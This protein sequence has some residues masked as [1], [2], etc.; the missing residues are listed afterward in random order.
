MNPMPQ[1]EP[2]LKQLRL[3]GVVDSLEAR[4]RQAIEGRLA[5]TDFLALLLQDE[6]ARR[7]QRHFAQRLRRAQVMGDK[8]LDRF[9]PEIC[10]GLNSGLLADLSTC[11]F[12]E[13]HAPVLVVGPPGTGKSHLAQALGHCALRAGYEVLFTTQSK[14]MTHMNAARATNGYGRRLQQLARIDL[15]IIDDFGLKPLRTPHDEDFHD[16]ISERYERKAILLTSNLDFEEWSAAFPNK[17]M[18]AA[19]LDRLRDGAYRV[20]LDGE[21]KRRFREIPAE[22]R[23]ADIRS[24]KA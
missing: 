11:R 16:L 7:D 1:L 24:K 17:L 14:L 6:I 18:A 12:I 15:I 9:K 13:E 22:M 19:T 4:N 23:G 20:L 10:P 5:Y 8:T 21:T 2:L 3:S